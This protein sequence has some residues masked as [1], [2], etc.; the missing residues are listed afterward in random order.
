MGQYSIK[1]IEQLSGVKAH[2]LRVWEQRYTILNPKRTDTNIRYYTD[3]DLK[4]VLNISV[5]N[6]HGMRIGKI[7]KMTFDD[8]E[9]EIAQLDNCELKYEVHANVL[10]TSM[11]EICER[12]FE[13]EMANCI[14]RYGMENTMLK[15]VYPFLQKIGL[16]WMTN[17]INPAHERFITNLIRQKL[18]V[19]IDGNEINVEERSSHFLLFLPEG[20]LHELSLLFLCYLLKSRNHRV[21]YLGV[22]VPFA[23]VAAVIKCIQP[24]F[25]YSILT[26]TQCGNNVAHFINNLSEVAGEK[27]V[28]IS[29]R[30]LEDIKL[31]A[32]SNITLLHSLDG[33]LNF[34]EQV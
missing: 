20:E 7:A 14:L 25:I 10:T 30:Q 33:V 31:N 6:R 18:I 12:K 8:I 17:K 34:I 13:K 27:K 24:E 16:M 26:C 5:L 19:A 15:V 21:T 22:N 29:G 2:T 23:D 1:D 11:I 32:T 3:E 4:K 28:V 9:G